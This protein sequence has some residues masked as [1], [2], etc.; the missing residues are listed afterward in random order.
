MVHVFVCMGGEREPCASR[1]EKKKY[2]PFPR[3]IN[4][5]EASDLLHVSS[6]NEFCSKV[7]VLSSGQ[8]HV[9]HNV[10]ESI[11]VRTFGLEINP[12]EPYV[13][14]TCKEIQICELTL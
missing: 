8:V 2:P 12:F 11:L 10:I 9:H 4:A 13:V 7:K 3:T 14:Q 6:S 1:W 5:E